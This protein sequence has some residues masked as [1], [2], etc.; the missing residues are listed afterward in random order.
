MRDAIIYFT[1]IVLAVAVFSGALGGNAAVALEPQPQISIT[2]LGHTRWTVADGAPGSIRA[3][4]QDG[5]G[6]LWIGTR[7]GLYRFD[8]VVFE[9]MKALDPEA[10]FGVAA[11]LAARDGSIWAAY[12]GGRIVIVGKHG[13]RDVSSPIASQVFVLKMLQGRD[14]AVWAVLGR[15]H[16][17][18]MRFTEGKWRPVSTDWGLPDQPVGDAVVA[19]NGDLWVTTLD[20]VM[21]LQSGA[22]RFVRAGEVVGG[23]GLSEDPAGHIWISDDTGSHVV[24]RPPQVGTP[25]GARWV[26]AIFD[27]EGSLWAANGTGI[28]RAR[29]LLPNKPASSRTPQVETFSAIQGLSANGTAPII[30]DREGNIWVGTSRGLDRFRSVGVVTVPDLGAPPTFGFRLFRASDGTVYIGG[31]NTVYRVR[32]AGEPVAFIEHV[33]ET[34][35][36]CEGSD[37]VVWIFLIGKVF[38]VQN[39]RAEAWPAPAAPQLGISDCAVDARG[40]L[41]ANGL[42]G[43]LFS[44]AGRTWI[45]HPPRN[46]QAWA[47]LL[48]TDAQRELVLFLRSGELVR[49]DANGNPTTVLFREPVSRVGAIYQ[50]HTSLLVDGSFGLARVKEGRVQILPAADFPWTRSAAGIVETSDRTWMITNAGVVGVDNSALAHAF[51]HP[52]TELQPTILSFIDGLPDIQN[53]YS[54]TDAALGADGRL[55]FATIGNVIWVDPK[56]LIR[57]ALPPSVTIRSLTAQR[58]YTAPEKIALRPGESNISIQYTATSLSIPERIKFRYRLA[59]ASGAWINAGARREA[60]FTNLAPGAYRFQVIAANSD[61]VWNNTGAHVDFTIPPTFLQSIWFK[62]L[63]AL[64]LLAL[65]WAGFTWRMRLEMGRLE[66]L[67]DTR[68]AERERIARELHDTLLQAIQGLLLQFQSV[69]DRFSKGGAQRKSLEAALDRAEAVLV[70]G[71][72]RVRELRTVAAGGGLAQA[73]VDIAAAEIG[74]NELQ[75][76]LTIEGAPREIHALVCEEMRRIGEEAIRN[77]VRHAQATTLEALIGYERLGVRLTL[78]DNGIGIDNETIEF[79]ALSGHYGLVGMRERAERIGAKFTLSSRRRQGTEVTLFVPGRT[80]FARRD[81]RL[82]SFLT[83]LWRKR[84]ER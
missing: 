15:P 70:E 81:Q 26:R 60:Y 82:P 59:G 80:A 68:I 45:A 41:W 25:G 66:S 48:I 33:P 74:G 67:F 23:A 28:W 62:F 16:D 53:R 5:D 14:G 84:L 29:V 37:G 79:G 46:D 8:G 27:H 49:A 1:R 39:G 63:V 38:R 9:D 30:E 71:R 18:L 44:L 58:T 10:A 73:L 19:R 22:K 32:G 47:E 65:L 64:T 11:L 83:G 75:F 55:W 69:A 76:H 21:V 2:Q 57:N 34:K 42:R 31:A 51:D 50:G 35:A 6:F 12:D 72:A 77:A 13:V 40:V 52:D 54:Y 24:G 20:T 56:R 36:M 43:G 17:A 78:R 4:A 3:L 7:T 61:G